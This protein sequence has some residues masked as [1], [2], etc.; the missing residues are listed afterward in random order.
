M[1]DQP[2]PEAE[3]MHRLRDE[4]AKGAQEVEVVH[5]TEGSR[6]VTR[7]D[8]LAIQ[9]TLRAANGSPA[10]R[11]MAQSAERRRLNAKFLAVLATAEPRHVAEGDQVGIDI[12]GQQF[13]V[14]GMTFVP[15][16]DYPPMAQPMPAEVGLLFDEQAKK[17]AVRLISH[18]DTMQ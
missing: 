12:Y 2:I 17:P 15:V 1:T 5:P 4:F 14:E 9:R 13:E 8:F 3:L 18:D 6:I 7:A 11:L 16:D 10:D